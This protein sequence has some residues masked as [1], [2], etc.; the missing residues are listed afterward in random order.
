MEIHF[1]GSVNVVPLKDSSNEIDVEFV[2]MVSV[3]PT[4]DG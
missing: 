4:D 3:A 1:D 2:E